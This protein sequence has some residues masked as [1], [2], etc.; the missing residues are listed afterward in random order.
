[1]STA[2]RKSN[3]EH[4]LFTR[5]D[6]AFAAH[7][8]SLT[9]AQVHAI[10][11]WQRSDRTY[12]LLQHVA[13]HD[14]GSDDLAA[15]EIS[16]LLALRRDLGAAIDSTSLP[17][18]IVV[19]RRVRSLFKTFGVACAGALVGRRLRLEG[20]LATSI[21]QAV[22]RREFTTAIWSS[23][24]DRGTG[25]NAGALGSGLRLAAASPPRRAVA[26]RG[27]ADTRRRVSS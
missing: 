2:G 26:S 14:V 11:T 9:P 27:P 22:A 15:S 25:W 17:F 19:H 12:E 6:R 13:R 21:L 5:L 20:Y 23:A 24:P 8:A 16:A 18:P 10:R 1:M 3:C 4:A 7:R